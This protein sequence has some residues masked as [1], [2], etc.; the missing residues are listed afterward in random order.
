MQ[1][2]VS[3]IKSKKADKI[4]TCNLCFYVR[5]ILVKVH[6][7]M[8]GE[9]GLLLERPI[10]AEALPHLGDENFALGKRKAG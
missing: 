1:D 7:L 4:F 3:K 6:I 2:L 5:L 9:T 10:E 8:R